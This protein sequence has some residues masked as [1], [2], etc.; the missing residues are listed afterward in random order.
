MP[1]HHQ[2]SQEFVQA[3]TRAEAGIHVHGLNDGLGDLSVLWER[4]LGDT[5]ERV[6]RSI[7]A[8]SPTADGLVGFFLAEH[9]DLSARLTALAESPPSA[10]RSQATIQIIHRL[11]QHVFLEARVLS[12]ADRSGPRADADARVGAAKAHVLHDT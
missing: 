3:L 1:D 2:D 6:F 11:I 12:P 4:H 10:E 5:E 9:A 8:A 7:V